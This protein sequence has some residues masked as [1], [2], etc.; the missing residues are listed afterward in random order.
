LIL[1]HQISPSGA[2]LSW[3]GLTVVIN[4]ICRLIV[5]RKGMEMS[6]SS[7]HQSALLVLPEFKSFFGARA[8]RL[9]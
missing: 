7:G 5:K 2:L 4:R 6:V 1:V 3:A 8:V 9:G